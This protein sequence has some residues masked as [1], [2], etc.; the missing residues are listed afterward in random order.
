MIKVL[1]ADDHAA[2][3][4]GIAA[5]LKDLFK[6]VGIVYDGRAL[7]AAANE[8]QPDVILTDITMPLLNGVNA[9]R[10]IITA[11][12]RSKIIVLTM[13]ADPELAVQAFRAGAS[14]YLLK[15]SPG[16]EIIAAIREVMQ[17][18]AYLS[19]LL[20]KDLISVLIEARSRAEPAGSSLTPRQL[21]VLQLIAEG[22]TMK[23]IATTL[24]ISP[25][26][27]ESHKYDMMQQLGV[28]TTAE[29]IQHAIRLKLITV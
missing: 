23:E 15:T 27:A 16:D 20:T 4:E 24:N 21:E 12:P 6:I 29:L 11:R 7:L 18:R 5:L 17:G 25:R 2:V 14:G 9:I 3:A 13:H 26:T 10:Q 1:L 28:Q 8:L 19:S 22:H